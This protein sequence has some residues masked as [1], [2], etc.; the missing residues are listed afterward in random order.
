MGITIGTFTSS[1]VLA[2]AVLYIFNYIID[3]FVTDPVINRVLKLVL[4]IIVLLIAFGVG[5]FI[6][7]S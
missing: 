4:I 3:F 5:L 2:A 6:K 7:V 1:F